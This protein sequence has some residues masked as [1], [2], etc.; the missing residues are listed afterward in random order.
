MLTSILKAIFGSKSARDAKR[1]AP[2]VKRI[3]ELEVS[4]QSLSE[5][6]LKAKTQEFKDRLAKGETLDDIL[7]EAFATVKNA[8]RRLCGTTAVVCDHELTWDMVPFDVQLIGGIALH[9]KKIAEMATGEG[10]TLVATMPLYLNAL[11]GKNCQLVTVNDY[12]ARRD[13][14][15]MGLVFKYLGLTVGCIQNEM[16]PE[17]RRAQYA[18][19]ITYGTNSE[20]GFDYLRDMGMASSKEQLVQRDHYFAII[21]EVDS[22]LIDEART[23]LIISGPVANSSHQFDVLRPA[24]ADLYNRQNLLCSRLVQEAKSVLDRENADADQQEE[25]ITKLLQVKMGMPQHKKLMHVL[26]DPEILKRVEKAEL[27]ARSEQNR[28]LLQEIQSEL[29]FSMEERNHEADLTE[30]GR[31]LI[32]GNDPN[33]FVLPDLLESLHDID[34]DASL[35]EADKIKKKQDFQEQFALKSEKL[36][37]I[38]QLLRAYCL[39]EKD[40][41]YV[42]QEG[43]VLIVDEHTGRILPGRRFSEGLHQALEAKENVSIEE[44]TQT[45]ATITIQNYFRLYEKLAGM[46]GTAETEASEFHQIYK[47]DVMVIPTNRPCRRVDYNDCVYKTKRE[48]FNAILKEV[49]ERYKKGQ[50]V[51]LGTISVEDSEVLSRMLK[52]RNIPHNVLNAKNHAR[53]SEIVARAGEKFAVT[54]ATNMAGRGTDIKL[55]DG[56][57]ELGGLYVIGSSR[58]DSRRIDRQLRGRSARQGDPGASRFYVSLEDNLMR[59]FGSDRIV[60]IMERFGLEEGEELQHPWLNKS[61]ETAQRRVEQHYFSIRKRTLEYDDVMNKQREVIYGIR[62]EILLNDSSRDFIF[63][64]VDA[65]VERRIQ[66]AVS[67]CDSESKETINRDNLL[68]WLNTTFPIGFTDE[69]FSFKEDGSPD[70]AAIQKAIVDRITE[71]YKLKETYEDP[72]GLKWLERHIIL[73]AIDRLWQEHLRAMDHLRSSIGLRA[74]AQKDPLIEYKQEAFKMFDE[75]IQAIDQEILVN[76]FRSATSLAAFEQLFAN[77]PQQFIAGGELP[78]EDVSA[79]PDNPEQDQEVPDIQISFRRDTPKVG[80]NEPC[81]CGSGKKYKNCCGK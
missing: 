67:L 35:S 42:V 63:D 18:C 48:K 7:C 19:D 21:D 78:M 13:S 15:W 24:I 73:D 52:M 66:V 62:K 23:P 68:G 17:E 45:F 77:I 79:N 34:A 20:F 47:L 61:I 14:E 41:H 70:T 3:N 50:P 74:Y 25:A 36:H 81:P 43:K 1:M 10:K 26:E 57:A 16:N 53:E 56:V 11:T 72:E 71:M 27:M 22:I 58:H 40:V 46:T 39:Y 12:L 80:R 38:S 60:K 33:A 2:L 31:V 54:V 8:C 28:G 75:L 29:F 76:M 9:K 37:D 65:E 5:E 4:Y 55:G 6:Q 69:I 32:S 64:T 30:K 49:E 51:L 59:I 44:E